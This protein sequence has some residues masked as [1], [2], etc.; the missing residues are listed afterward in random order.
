MRRCVVVVVSYNKLWKKL[1][2]LKMKKSHLRDTAGLSTNVM[3]RLSK[4]E[5][6]SMDS[7]MKICDVLH[8][9]I[10]EILEIISDDHKEEQ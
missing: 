6:V 7:L 8:C 4:D 10:G 9:D 3:A 2:D 1:I 5:T